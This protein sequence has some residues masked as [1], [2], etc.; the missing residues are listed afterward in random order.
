MLIVKEKD[1]FILQRLGQ[2]R[3]PLRFPRQRPVPFLGIALNLKIIAFMK[4]RDLLEDSVLIN[5]EILWLES[6]NTP[7]VF[8]SNEDFDIRDR[9]LD[10][11]NELGGVF[12][13]AFLG[14]P[15]RGVDGRRKG[16]EKDAETERRREE[17]PP[18]FFHPMPLLNRI[19]IKRPHVKKG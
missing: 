17:N 11:I 3:Y 8:A 15:K 18:G 1:D 6:R 14:P 9:D 13:L 12:G 10:I 2:R 4:I 7:A 5:L 19:S 16:G